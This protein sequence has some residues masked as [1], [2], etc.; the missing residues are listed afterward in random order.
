MIF[1]RLEQTKLRAEDLYDHNQDLHNNNYQV[2][3]TSWNVC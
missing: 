3:D 1:F 2:V